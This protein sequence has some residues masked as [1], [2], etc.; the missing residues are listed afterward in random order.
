[1]TLSETFLR[2]NMEVL[3]PLKI[4]FLKKLSYLLFIYLAAV[5]LSCGTLCL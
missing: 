3:F 1:M 5:G 4:F 2:K